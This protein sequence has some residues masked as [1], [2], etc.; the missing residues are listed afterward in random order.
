VAKKSVP[1]STSLKEYLSDPVEAEGY[2]TEARKDSPEAYKTAL[3]NVAMVRR[4]NPVPLT[5][6]LAPDVTTWLQSL[7]KRAPRRVNAILR[8]AMKAE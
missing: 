8:A 7:G 5:L 3:R 4:A 1:Y 2:L 6:E